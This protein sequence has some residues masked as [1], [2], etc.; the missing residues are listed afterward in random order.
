MGL[1]DAVIPEPPG[2]AHVNHE[3]LFRSV[4]DVIGRQLRELDK[5]PL[6]QLPAQRYRKFRDMGRLGREFREAEP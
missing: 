6:D 3:E 2:G 5:V 4:D 1:V